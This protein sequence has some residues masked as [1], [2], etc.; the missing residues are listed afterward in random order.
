VKPIV[1]PIVKP[2]ALVAACL[3]VFGLSLF[4]QRGG[5]AGAQGAAGAQ[6]A[7][8]AQGAGEEE[9][10]PLGQAMDGLQ[11]G[12]RAIG[13]LL[14]DPDKKDEASSTAREMQNYVL[15]AMQLEPA[16]PDGVEAGRHQLDFRMEMHAVLG[17]LLALELA[18]R[19]GDAEGAKTRFSTLNGLKKAGHDRF[20]V[21]D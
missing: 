20:R 6:A 11:S 14:A 8:G 13:R 17:E 1:K 7:A 12:M 15:I 16:A 9:E 3:V 19:E 5:G 21:D 10:S 18:V 4:A 2:V